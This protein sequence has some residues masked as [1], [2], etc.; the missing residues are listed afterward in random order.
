M[1]I[2]SSAGLGCVLGS[3]AT[4]KLMDRDYKRAEVRYRTSKG[5]AADAEI[6]N[7]THPDFPLERARLGQVWWMLLLFCIS[8][9]VYGY[10][11]EWHIA[12]PLIMQF[13]GK[14]SNTS[15][16]HVLF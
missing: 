8:T 11:T 10:S 2:N 7:E 16:T 9:G 12:V 15:I 5:L 4:G 13:I 6:K 1:Q 3:L 14:H